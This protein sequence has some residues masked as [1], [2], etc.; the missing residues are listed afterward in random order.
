[1][2]AIRVTLEIAG[3]QFILKNGGGPSVRLRK[4]AG[5]AKL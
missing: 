2:R 5:R 3:V 4:A 1:M